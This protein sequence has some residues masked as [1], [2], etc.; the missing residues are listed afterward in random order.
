MRFNSADFKTFSEQPGDHEGRLTYK[1]PPRTLY[2]SAYKERWFKLKSN[3]LFYY[4]LNEFGGV[5]KNEPSGVFVL[6]NIE[7]NRE[8]TTELPFGFAITWK[9]EPDKK[10][11]FFTHNENSLYPWISKLEYASY[12]HLKTQLSMLRMKILR[13]S[14][15]DPLEGTPLPKQA[16]N[17]FSSSV[18]AKSSFHRQI[19]SAPNSP[20]TSS[21]IPTN[22]AAYSTPQVRRAAPLPPPRK[23]TKKK[24]QSQGNGWKLKK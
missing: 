3:F 10:F 16:Q 20:S 8:E 2:D 18:L 6:E 14:G 19:S 5:E 12:Q 17:E 15:K 7:I 21:K 1:P 23:H 13:K 22:V 11:Q 4:R 24:E 9:D